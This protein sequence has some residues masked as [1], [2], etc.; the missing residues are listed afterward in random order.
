[1]RRV[2]SQMRGEVLEL[3]P[4]TAARLVRR[5]HLLDRAIQPAAEVEELLQAC[6]PGAHA[7]VHEY[8]ELRLQGRPSRRQRDTV[9]AGQYE[10]ALDVGGGVL[11]EH[12][13][14]AV[15]VFD[16][17]RPRIAQIPYEPVR[18]R[19][20]GELRRGAQ[21]LTREVEIARL[22]LLSARQALLQD[23]TSRAPAPI[24]EKPYAA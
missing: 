10:R 9:S 12:R 2:A 18:T 8:G 19:S 7:R 22:D 11:A 15:L 24:D 4:Q 1:M 13:G 23:R 21:P 5:P 6:R 3:L 20:S 16:R 14:D 17:P